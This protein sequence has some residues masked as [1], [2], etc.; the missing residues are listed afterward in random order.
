M[1]DYDLIRRCY[2]DNVDALNGVLT[3]R[4]T[5]SEMDI[6]RSLRDPK[7]P[8]PK[9][10]KELSFAIA[11]AF[12]N[13]QATVLSQ[14]T[15]FNRDFM[16]VLDIY[17]NY[18]CN[19]TE[20]EDILHKLV[21]MLKELSLNELDETLAKIN[22]NFRLTD[23]DARYVKQKVTQLIEMPPSWQQKGFQD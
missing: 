6:L 4:L 15:K 14:A 16:Y 17:N 20:R 10:E 8:A 9:S 12:A 3:N 7:P 1:Y 5:K 21:E 18:K 23:D 2:D 13:N 19:E 11:L 22:R